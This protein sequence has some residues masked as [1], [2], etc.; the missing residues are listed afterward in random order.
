LVLDDCERLVAACAE[1]V[2]Q[3]LQGCPRLRLLVTS[4]EPLAVAGEVV[5]RVD[6]LAL[7]NPRESRSLHDITS[8]A[9]A[10]LFIA[11]AAATGNS[12]ALDDASAA[13]IARICVAVDGLPLALELAAARTRVLTVQQLADRLEHDTRV[14][15]D[16]KRAA[17]P[18]H[19]TIRATIDWSYD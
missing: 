2:V 3:L 6:P 17:R 15:G 9:A 5:W 7:P 10:R 12:L 11:R 1:M 4:R 14:L 13:S 18:Q 16:L 19:Q 8:T